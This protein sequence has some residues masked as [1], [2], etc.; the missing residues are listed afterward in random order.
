MVVQ[1]L[2]KRGLYAQFKVCTYIKLKFISHPV[3]ILPVWTTFRNG[4][5]ELDS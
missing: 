3:Y 4:P 5:S 2:P 1:T